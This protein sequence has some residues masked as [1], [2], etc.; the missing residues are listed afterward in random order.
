MVDR[1]GP[2]EAWDR[3]MAMNKNNREQDYALVPYWTSERLCSGQTHAEWRAEVDAIREE[4][5][6]PY[7][8][9]Y[10]DPADL[11]PIVYP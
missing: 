1:Y 7:V 4:M 6:I 2:Q 5:G 11:P 8:H 3:L 9:G 10:P